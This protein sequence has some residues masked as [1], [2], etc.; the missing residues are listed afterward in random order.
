M[1]Q[2]N[3][4]GYSETKPSIK[5]VNFR[6]RQFPSG[7]YRDLLTHWFKD[8]KKERARAKRSLTE[9]SEKLLARAVNLILCGN[10]GRGLRLID[11]NGVSPQEDP[12][13]REQMREKHPSPKEPVE[14]PELPEFGSRL[15]ATTQNGSSKAARACSE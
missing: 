12:Q 8:V 6:L 7:N 11:S 2:C 3:Y 14:W 10:I 9:S 1:I 13:V 4:P 5:I 15:R